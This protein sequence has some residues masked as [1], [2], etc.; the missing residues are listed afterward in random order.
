MGFAAMPRAMEDDYDWFNKR[1][2]DQKDST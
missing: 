1:Y 2:P